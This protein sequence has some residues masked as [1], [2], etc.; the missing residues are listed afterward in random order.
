VGEHLKKQRLDL[1]R[2]Q[3]E[4][5]GEIGVREQTYG[6]WEQERTEPE[7]RFY[8]AIVRFLGYDPTPA[9]PALS[10][11]E[12][13]RVARRARG[14]SLEKTAELLGVDPTTLWKWEK[15][16]ASGRP[17]RRVLWAVKEF[18]RGKAGER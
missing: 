14:L 3:K 17:A 8:P 1:G 18:L 7:I 9:D 2:T 13:L 15:R 5:A 6:Y 11:G 4:V 10:I 16:G 12:R